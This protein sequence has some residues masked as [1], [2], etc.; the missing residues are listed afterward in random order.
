[1]KER[2]KICRIA[3]ESAKIVGTGR[4][5]SISLETFNK[6]R[7]AGVETTFGTLQ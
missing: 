1:M 6:W 3:T 5:S 2:N 4:E 7:D